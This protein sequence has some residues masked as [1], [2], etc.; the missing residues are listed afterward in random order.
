MQGQPTLAQLRAELISEKT[1]RL[2]QQGR[3]PWQPTTSSCASSSTLSQRRSPHT[4]ETEAD[5]GTVESSELHASATTTQAQPRQEEEKDGADAPA[6][7]QR[8]LEVRY[9]LQGGK[10]GQWKAGTQTGALHIPSCHLM[11]TRTL[12]SHPS[13]PS[14]RA[15]YLV[16]QQ[17]A[18]LTSLRLLTSSRQPLQHVDVP[19][20]RGLSLSPHERVDCEPYKVEVLSELNEEDVAAFQREREERGKQRQRTRP[21]TNS[22]AGG[23]AVAEDLRRGIVRVRDVSEEER[24]RWSWSL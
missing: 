6:A 10:R 14:L 5:V 18:H 4:D 15:G 9:Q 12:P 1:R 20:S 23:P 11:S 22:L 3:A 7:L 19:S 24:T 13:S 17:S 16:S 21:L 2:M 8:H